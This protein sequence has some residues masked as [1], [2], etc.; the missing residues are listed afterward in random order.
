MDLNSICKKMLP[1]PVVVSFIVTIPLKS[2]IRMTY[3]KS[4][5]ECRRQAERSMAYA[6]PYTRAAIDPCARI[7]MVAQT[8]FRISRNAR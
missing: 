6:R 3:K 8:E 5:A 2:T 1:V 7:S 4:A